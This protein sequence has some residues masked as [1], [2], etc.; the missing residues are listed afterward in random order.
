MKPKKT[1]LD[2]LDIFI[3]IVSIVVALLFVLELNDMI[4]LGSLKLLMMMIP[5]LVVSGLFLR[6]FIKKT[7]LILFTIV[8]NLLTSLMVLMNFWSFK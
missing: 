2:L 7:K 8:L 4:N 1:L 3:F 6:Y 5:P